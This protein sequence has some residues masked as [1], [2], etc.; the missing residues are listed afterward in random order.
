MKRSLAGHS[1][2]DVT[3]ENAN[4]PLNSGVQFR[5]MDHTRTSR[6]TQLESFETEIQ[7]EN[8]TNV[9][10]LG[11]GTSEITGDSLLPR[12]VNYFNSPAVLLREETV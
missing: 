10:D 2:E 8:D 7:Q 5:A 6:R 4:F 1:R 9:T 12:G 3:V 11:N